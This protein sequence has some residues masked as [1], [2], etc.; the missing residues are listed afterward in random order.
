MY[1]IFISQSFLNKSEK[2]THTL[3]ENVIYMEDKFSIK[4]EGNP[5]IC[6]NMEYLEGTMLNEISDTK[7]QILCDLAYMWNPKME[8][9]YQQSLTGRGNGETL[10][11][12]YKVSLMQ[13]RIVLKFYYTQYP[14]LT[15]NCILISF[16]A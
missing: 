7:R 15:Q 4:K 9:S 11:K 16:R 3:E 5:V 13:D 12:R 2:H 8:N 1:T 14:Q 6:D 10:V